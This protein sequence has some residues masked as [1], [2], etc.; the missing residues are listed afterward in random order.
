MKDIKSKIDLA[1]EGLSIL[2]GMV[3][4]DGNE[5]K[6]LVLLQNEMELRATGGFIGSYGIMTF[7]NGKLLEFD[8]KDVYAADAKQQEMPDSTGGLIALKVPKDNTVI[9]SIRVSPR[10]SDVA[11]VAWKEGMYTVYTQKTAKGGDAAVLLEGGQKD[12][13]NGGRGGHRIHDFPRYRRSWEHP[14]REPF[15]VSRGGGHWSPR[16]RPRSPRPY[17]DS[18]AKQ[19]EPSRIFL[20]Y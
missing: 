13:R 10:G 3:G 16:R 11:Y 14:P 1:V 2:P 12:R 17:S 18:W 5:K 6:Y 9:R 19:G 4:A 8:I 15:L 7:K 20:T